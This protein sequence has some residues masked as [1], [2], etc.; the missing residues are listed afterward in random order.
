MEITY[1]SLIL[2]I[3]FP[4]FLLWL[5]K[6]RVS[7]SIGPEARGLAGYNAKLLKIRV[8]NKPLIAKLKLPGDAVHQCEAHIVRMIDV[9]TGQGVTFK[10]SRL[11][12]TRGIEPLSFVPS[13]MTG[14]PQPIFDSTKMHEAEVIDLVPNKPED[15]DLCIKHNGDRECYIFNIW[16]YAPF[17]GKSRPWS[18]P[19]NKVGEGTYRVEVKV[20]G[21]KLKVF[22]LRNVGINLD[23]FKLEKTDI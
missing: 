16:N 4:L 9:A 19:D 2:S 3:V 22:T 18:H 10:H 1:I 21:C 6:P 11:K 13:P 15:F 7:L 8:I 14:R 20:T 23:D 17:P 5:R 12:W